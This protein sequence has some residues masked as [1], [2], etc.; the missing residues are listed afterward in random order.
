MHA[1]VFRY[2]LGCLQL[3]LLQPPFV[4]AVFFVQLL[5]HLV[6]PLG[7]RS[8]LVANGALQF[9]VR[10]L[11]ALPTAAR[12]AVAAVATQTTQSAGNICQS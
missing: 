5:G 1:P 8:P 2:L 6:L 3:L 4:T 12:L 10:V 7:K 9:L 11:S